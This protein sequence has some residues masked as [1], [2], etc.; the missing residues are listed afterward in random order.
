MSD[1]P[2]PPWDAY[3]RPIAPD[4]QLEELRRSIA[5]LRGFNEY[6]WPDHGN[7]ALAIA[8]SYALLV[9]AL[10]SIAANTCCDQCRE[11]ALVA[12]KALCDGDGTSSTTGNSGMNK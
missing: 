10:K 12:Q 3:P 2:I 6:T 5:N 1:T 8:A 7:A 4:G 9:Q 11:A